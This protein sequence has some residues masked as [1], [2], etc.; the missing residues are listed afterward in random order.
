MGAYRSQSFSPSRSEQ[1]RGKGGD[2]QLKGYFLDDPV[3]GFSK[4]KARN[5]A[6]AAAENAQNRSMSM[7]H[8]IKKRRQLDGRAWNLANDDAERAELRHDTSGD[9]INVKGAAARQKRPDESFRGKKFGRDDADRTSKIGRLRVLSRQAGNREATPEQ[10]DMR[11]P[12][13]DDDDGI[14]AVTNAVQAVV[15]RDRIL[16]KE[17]QAAQIANRHSEEDGSPWRDDD[18]DATM[19]DI[20]DENRQGIDAP[21]G[22]VDFYDDVSHYS[23]SNGDK[24]SHRKLHQSR[25]S[26]RDSIARKDSKQLPVRPGSLTHASV[27]SFGREKERKDGELNTQEMALEASFESLGVSDVLASHLKSLGFQTPTKIQRDS[28]PLLLCKPPRDALIRAATGSGKTLSY[29]VPVLQDLASLQPKVTRADGT[30]ALIL[31]PTRELCLQVTDVFTLLTR[32]FVWIVPGAVHGGEHRGKEKAKLRKG[33]GALVATPGRLL[34][35][36]TNTSS[37]R[38]S[39]MRWMVLDEADRLLDL[40]FEKKIREILYSLESRSDTEGESEAKDESHDVDRDT[41]ET[42]IDEDEVV[43]ESQGAD[44]P[45]LCTSAARWRTILLSATLHA[46]LSSLVCLSLQDPVPIGFKIS[47]GA[48]G[49]TIDEGNAFTTENH[50]SS[51]FQL[52]NSLVQKFL[53]VPT[54]Q[55]LVALACL[56]Q[57]RLKA[58]PDCAKIVVFFA[59]CDAVDFYH[60]LFEHDGWRS[61][62]G[63]SFAPSTSVVLKLHGDMPPGERTRA[64]LAFTKSNTGVLLCTDVA[65][66]GLDFPA[67]TSIVQ[68]DPP[69]AIEEYVHRVG[70]TARLGASGEAIVFLTPTEM[71]YVR[72]MSDEGI[73]MKRE[74][75]RA[76]LNAALEEQQ[77]QGAGR[78]GP[79]PI[80]RH[81]G[82]RKLQEQV[83]RAVNGDLAL[84][85]KAKA[86]FTSYVRAYATHTA[87]MK[88]I[89][90]F[91]KLHLGHVAHSFALRELPRGRGAVSGGSN[92]NRK[93]RIVVRKDDERR[94]RMHLRARMKNGPDESFTAVSAKGSG[95]YVLT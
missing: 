43:D 24:S 49:L 60:A 41:S 69:R 72:H 51:P 57:A 23:R 94:G 44:V 3:T 18:V 9:V 71:E 54:K 25:Q 14:D 7:I 58:S 28:I 74:S 68:F 11:N 48:S 40:G 87:E 59:T 67:V 33:V 75:V 1:R 76:I 29:A 53:E 37:F 39:R 64:L 89:F 85:P 46:G 31:T 82:A 81:D 13:S 91:K 4:D 88:G 2:V 30:L 45:G 34:D 22:V 56:L 36:L 79:V 26:A 95:G 66:R 20:G 86:A 47:Q 38:T 17:L 93:E 80:E 32:R 15:Q 65:A 84:L 27:G 61:A 42:D 55:R 83:M 12:D 63:R 70:R 19:R 8:P 16:V 73:S 10:E 6:V 21:A 78:A 92:P 90:S 35:H 50:G 62:T 5:K 77:Q 52:P